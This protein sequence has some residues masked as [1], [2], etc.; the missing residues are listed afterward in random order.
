MLLTN[1]DDDCAVLEN[2]KPPQWIPQK[3]CF[4]NFYNMCVNMSKKYKA[5]ASYGNGGCQNWFIKQF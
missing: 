4:H 1:A 3:W 5:N 2:C